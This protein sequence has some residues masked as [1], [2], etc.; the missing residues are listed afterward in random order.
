MQQYLFNHFCTFDHCGFLDDVSLT[1]VNKTDHLIRLRG[2]TTGEAH[3]RLCHHLGLILKK[4]YSSFITNILK[5]LYFYKAGTV[6]GQRFSDISLISGVFLFLRMFF[7]CCYFGYYL[8][9]LLLSSSLLFLWLPLLSLFLFIFV[10]TITIY[11]HQVITVNIVIYL[12]TIATFIA[13]IGRHN[14]PIWFIHSINLVIYPPIIYANPIFTAAVVFMVSLWTVNCIVKN[15]I[16][17]NLI[18]FLFIV[19]R[20]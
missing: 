14:T 1:F 8:L 16:S 7:I 12:L 10:F 15:Y 5:H 6:W 4:V 11:F 2:K 9:F 13:S 3:L 20:A 19:W 17:A 18:T